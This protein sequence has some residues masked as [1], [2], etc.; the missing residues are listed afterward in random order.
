MDGQVLQIHYIHSNRH[1]IWSGCGYKQI[2]S[3]I[4]LGKN[5]S[6][7]KMK[8]GMQKYSDPARIKMLW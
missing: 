6:N 1:L 2:H 4:F 5:G 8:A 7:K 3:L